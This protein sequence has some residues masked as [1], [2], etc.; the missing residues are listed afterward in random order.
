MVDPTV[1]D[2]PV[3]M[4]FLW[5][6][7]YFLNPR[8]VSTTVYNIPQSIIMFPIAACGLWEQIR[9]FETAAEPQVLI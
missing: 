6:M 5:G 1:H 4:F 2:S 8:V 7:R 3:R 9:W